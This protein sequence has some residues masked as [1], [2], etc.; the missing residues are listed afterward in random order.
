MNILLV[1]LPVFPTTV[2][3]TGLLL[4]SDNDN[5]ERAYGH[6]ERAC[7]ADGPQQNL[8]GEEGVTK[9]APGAKGN[10]EINL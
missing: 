7:L 2:H 8:K 4:Q 6:G 9:K 5:N 3:R 10:Q 1:V